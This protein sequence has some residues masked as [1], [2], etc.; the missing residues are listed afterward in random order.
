MNNNSTIHNDLNT[1]IFTQHA[2]LHFYSKKLTNGYFVI[3]F[4]KNSYES[5]LKYITCVLIVKMKQQSRLKI[6]RK[7]IVVSF[8]TQHERRFK[9]GT[10]ILKGL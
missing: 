3:W 2:L 5:N 9:Y 4:I 8:C 6:D 1:Y 7:F 10:D